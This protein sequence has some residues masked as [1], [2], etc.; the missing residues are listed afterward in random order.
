M[1]TNGELQLIILWL[2][3]VNGELIV[4]PYMKNPITKK[5][6]HILN[7]MYINI[8]LYIRLTMLRSHEL[9]P[10]GDMINQ[11]LA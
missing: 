10:Y 6:S 1:V 3:M 11:V 9:S 5:K 8:S 7:Y 4:I 2:K